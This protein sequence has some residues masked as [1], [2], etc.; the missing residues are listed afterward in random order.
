MNDKI[1]FIE[2]G[3]NLGF[4][5][6][7]NIGFHYAKYELHSD[8]IILANNDLIFEQVDFM[9]QIEKVNDRESY[10]CCWSKN[11]LVG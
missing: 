10:R 9:D 4:A 7:N 5:K 3:E 2:S 11:H 8:I 1:H 6:G